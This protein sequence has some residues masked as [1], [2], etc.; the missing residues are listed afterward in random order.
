MNN[1]KITSVV[2]SKLLSIIPIALFLA[3]VVLFSCQ[4]T[5]DEKN[6]V[7]S[8]ITAENLQ[9]AYSKEVNRH[10][11]YEAFSAR[12]EKDK[13]K[14][15]ALLYRAI[16]R[17]E[18]IHSLCN[19][20]LLHNLGVDPKLPKDEYITVGTTPQTLKMA[21]SMEDIEYGTMYKNMIRC[22]EVEHHEDCV[23]VLKA[24]QDA[25]S[26]HAELLRYAVYKGKEMP[27]LQY[28]VCKECGYLITT[29]QTDDCPA[30]KAKRETFEKL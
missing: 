25:E 11:M 6:G 3:I 26:K 27:A 1:K 18:E 16:A 23:K 9:T 17:S 30:C 29:E 7:K 20:K 24:I 15:I 8:T 21:L 10:K 13:M 5:A 4:K 2:K 14:Q 19:L 12:A 22:A 28:S